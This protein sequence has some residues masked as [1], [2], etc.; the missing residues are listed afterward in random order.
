LSFIIFVQNKGLPY[1]RELIP[2]L[3][4][5]DII[6]IKEIAVKGDQWIAPGFGLGSQIAIHEVHPFGAETP[7]RPGRT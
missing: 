1:F 6:V 3:E 7:K 5:I 4:P 2:P